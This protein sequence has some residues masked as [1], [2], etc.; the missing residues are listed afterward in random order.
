MRKYVT[1]VAASLLLVATPVFAQ[2]ADVQEK[3]AA[4]QAQV[5]HLLQM[6]AQLKGESVPAGQCLDLKNNFGPNDTDSTTGGEVTRLQQF[7][8]S[9]GHMRTGLS[10]GYFGPATTKALQQWQAQHGI[11]SNGSPQ[12]TGWGRLGPKTAA[13][14]AL[15]TATTAVPAPASTPAAPSPAPEIIFGSPAPAPSS[16]LSQALRSC[17]IAGII[18]ASGE[19]RVFYAALSVRAPA[20]C[21]SQT[22]TCTDGQ[23][24]GSYSFGSCVVD[25]SAGALS[26]LSAPGTSQTADAS[27]IL[28][29]SNISQTTGNSTSLDVYVSPQGS[30]SAS[31]SQNAPLKTIQ[32]AQAKVRQVRAGATGDIHVYLRGG[33]YYLDQTLVFGASDSNTTYLSY[34]GERAILSGGMLITNFTQSTADPKLFYAYL[35][36]AGQ[37]Q[38]YSNAPMSDQPTAVRYPSNSEF[39]VTKYSLTPGSCDGTGNPAK[40]VNLQ[41]ITMQVPTMLAPSSVDALGGSELVILKTFAQSRIRVGRVAITGPT[42]LTVYPEGSSAKFEGCNYDSLQIPG[43]RAHFEGDWHFFEAP[44]IFNPLSGSYAFANNSV[45]FYARSADAALSG[46]VI[47][48]RLEKILVIDGAQNFTFDGI[49]LEHAAWNEPSISG[50]VVVSRASPHFVPRSLLRD[51]LCRALSVLQMRRISR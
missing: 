11:V 43:Y 14:M 25:I 45:Y 28:P 39:K 10:F 48:P 19:S 20:N 7:L 23:L 33:T 30:D 5:Q 9:Q 26:A 12:T 3:I 22:R 35:G 37:R 32:A 40:T 21:I 24:S 42:E 51:A 18:L 1:A 36:A 50:Y 31:G 44:T 2:S 38:L 4:L 6:V 41:S 17:S 34:P 47:V 8:I 16:P 29:T 46:G 13:A 27:S 49:D 15:C